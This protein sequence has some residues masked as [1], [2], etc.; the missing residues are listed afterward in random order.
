MYLCLNSMQLRLLLKRTFLFLYTE[1]R[2]LQIFHN[3]C[4]EITGGA[5]VLKLC[6][7]WVKNPKGGLPFS[8][9]SIKQSDTVHGWEGHNT[10]T[11]P[12]LIQWQAS[13]EADDVTYWQSH[14][15]RSVLSHSLP[16]AGSCA[17]E[18]HSCS[19]TLSFFSLTYAASSTLDAWNRAVHLKAGMFD[20]C[21]PVQGV[22]GAREKDKMNGYIEDG[23]C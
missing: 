14:S 19:H 20:F 17:T 9:P 12:Q 15:K 10:R 22:Q 18:K 2:L 11:N 7:F 3:F 4:F 21:S 8:L 23:K 16:A 1:F 13:E 5:V 6:G